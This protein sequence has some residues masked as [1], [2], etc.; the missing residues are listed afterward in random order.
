MK[1]VKLFENF[2]NETEVLNHNTKEEYTG[3]PYMM[4]SR[5]QHD[6]EYFLGNGKGSEKHL[7]QGSV[8]KQIAYMKKIWN[9]LSKK[10]EWLSMEEIEDY[11]NKMK[12]YET[13]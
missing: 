12:N 3:N 8:E 2:L 1:H 13:H 11:E 10:P 6:C 9:G 7:H 5:L 4:L